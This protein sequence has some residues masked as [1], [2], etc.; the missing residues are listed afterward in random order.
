[1]DGNFSKLLKL[2]QLIAFSMMTIVLCSKNERRLFL[3]IL[4][5]LAGSLIATLMAVSGYLEDTSIVDKARASV[6]E[7]NANKFAFTMGIAII[8][9]G[10]LYARSKKLGRYIFLGAV[11]VFLY[12]LIISASRGAIVALSVS[13]LTYMAINNSKLKSAKN[14][15]IFLLIVSTILVVGLKKGFIAEY[16]VKR[17]V[18]T[19]SLENT[20]MAYRFI[21][22]RTG[23]KI[24]KDNFITG[25]GLGNF[26]FAYGKYTGIYASHVSSPGH[27]VDPHNTYLS[28]L[29]ETGFIGFVLFLSFLS[30]IF[31]FM[32]KTKSESKVF[33]ICLLIFISIV[34]VK[35]TMHFGKA[36]WS[37]IA[38][39]YLIGTCSPR[40][41]HS[42]KKQEPEVI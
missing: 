7:Q 10:F 19:R 15:L 35:G 22:W 34:A 5:F 17:I 14:I 11:F 9:S 21:I 42:G 38:L 20:T 12:G 4:V 41:L 8:I 27:E 3:I 25:V 1:M 40:H 13:F 23:W 28:I 26:K 36:Y 30:S 2:F 37:C 31:L 33:G 32:Y 24:V 6:K 16:S 39:S 29:A 18:D